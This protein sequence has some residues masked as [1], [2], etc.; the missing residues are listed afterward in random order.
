MS[1][2]VEVRDAT[3][4]DEA[5]LM[6]LCRLLHEENGKWAMNESNVRFALRRAFNRDRALMGVVDRDGMI[7]GCC[8]LY[9]EQSWYSDQLFLEELFNYV[10][11]DHRRAPVA[12]S[13]IGWTKTASDRLAIPLMIGVISNRRTAAKVR[14]YER[15]LEKAGAFFIHNAHLA[16][17]GETSI[18]L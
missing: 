3:V 17:G 18:A 5:E 7:A 10:H 15:Q 1:D 6:N 14:L 12:K 13:L 2:S 4:A 16:V 11:P 8:Y 9:V